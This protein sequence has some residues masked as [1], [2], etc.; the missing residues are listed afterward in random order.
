MRESHYRQNSGEPALQAPKSNA[1]NTA[2]Y[3]GVSALFL[4][5]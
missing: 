2:L 3:C 1:N 4:L 5:L